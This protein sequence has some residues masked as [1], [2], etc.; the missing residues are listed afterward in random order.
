MEQELSAFDR[1]ED[2]EVPRGE[3]GHGFRSAKWGVVCPISTTPQ[4]KPN[5][6]ISVFSRNITRDFKLFSHADV[7]RY[8]TLLTQDHVKKM[9]LM[10][11]IAVT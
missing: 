5:D 7:N 1:G 11:G 2:Y 9:L 3:S 10:G 6:M 4:Q 8:D